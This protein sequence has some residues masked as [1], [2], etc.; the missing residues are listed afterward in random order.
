ME[1]RVDT[2][3]FKTG[4]HAKYYNPG[5]PQ[6]SPRLS[7]LWYWFLEKEIEKTESTDSFLN[8]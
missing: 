8:I 7:V 4:R 1:A 5:I 2:D 6:A 3:A